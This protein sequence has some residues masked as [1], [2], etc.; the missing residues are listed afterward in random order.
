GNVYDTDCRAARFKS[1]RDL[2]FDHRNN[3]YIADTYN[4]QIKCVDDA[5]G[6]VRLV[7]GTGVDGLWDVLR[8]RFDVAATS[9]PLNH[10]H[11]VQLATN[12]DILIADSWNN[13]VYR[14]V[15]G[16]LQLFA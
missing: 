11:A 4:N 9:S 7:A 8:P 16:R 12:G 5:D 2:A 1:I 10:P 3:L 6:M 13:A 14:L 15:G